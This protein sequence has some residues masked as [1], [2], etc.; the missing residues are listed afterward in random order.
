V[1]KTIGDNHK[2]YSLIIILNVR[3]IVSVRCGVLKL[4]NLSH[5]TMLLPRNR[6]RVN[7]SSDPGSY[8][9]VEDIP[10]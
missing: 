9:V 10:C 3:I 2:I 7:F 1:T 4:S 5:L 8:V 6:V